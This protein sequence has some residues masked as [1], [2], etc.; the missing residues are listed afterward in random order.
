MYSG[1]KDLAWRKRLIKTNSILAVISF[2]SDLFYP[3][4]SV[5]CVIVVIKKKVPHTNHTKT[6]FAR[7]TDDGFTKL[8]KR[9]LPH[10]RDSQLDLL[11]DDIKSFIEG[12]TINEVPGLIQTKSF[13]IEDKHL[14]IIPQQY[15][16]NA[17]LDTKELSDSLGSIYS[18]LVFQQIRRG[19]K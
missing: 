12:G 1:G 15:L 10:G 9:R 17:A 3:Q 16:D 5:E 4:A 14:E 11:Q 13:D 6:L 8:K 19:L 18:E 2:P 7:I